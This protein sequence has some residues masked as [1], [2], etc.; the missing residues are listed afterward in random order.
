M[1]IIE[2]NH[3][4]VIPLLKK[5]VE[6]YWLDDKDAWL[7]FTDGSVVCVHMLD[8]TWDSY[9]TLTELDRD[10]G[11][12][13]YDEQNLQYFSISDRPYTLRIVGIYFDKAKY[14]YH[15]DFDRYVKR[16]YLPVIELHYYEAGEEIG[17]C[18]S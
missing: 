5:S 14:Y 11:T 10:K 17:D 18:D 6:E 8:P 15:R 7:K 9:V 4:T 12:C 1:Q 3:K 13:F 2:F 16:E